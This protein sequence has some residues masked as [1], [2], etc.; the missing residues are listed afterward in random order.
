M[1][2]N[3]ECNCKLLDVVQRDV[4]RLA[5]DMCDKRAVQPRLERKRFLRPAQL[6]SLSDYVQGKQLSR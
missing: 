4:S 5:L 6:A 1:H 3:T 2:T